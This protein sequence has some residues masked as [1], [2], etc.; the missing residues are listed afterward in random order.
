MTLEDIFFSSKLIRCQEG[1]ASQRMG[2]QTVTEVRQEQTDKDPGS[3]GRVERPVLGTQTVT[4][5][6]E[7]HTDRD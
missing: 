1:R 4:K 3:Y 7:E 5:V 2:T 6:R